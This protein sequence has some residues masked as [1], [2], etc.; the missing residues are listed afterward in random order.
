MM[1]PQVDH[2]PAHETTV[3]FFARLLKAIEKFS[4]VE[5]RN[6]DIFQSNRLVHLNQQ[7]LRTAA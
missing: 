7:E 2:T 3:E 5:A 6:T 1:P 4:N